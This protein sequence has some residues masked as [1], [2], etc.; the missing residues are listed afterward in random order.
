MTD[1]QWRIIKEMSTDDGHDL[2]M[3]VS[4]EKVEAV[5]ALMHW[6]IL[7]R[8]LAAVS[9]EDVRNFTLNVAKAQ[10]ERAKQAEARVAELEAALQSMEKE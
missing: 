3:G 6:A 2:F 7:V 5:L 4:Q 8:S 10:H 9:K 1:E